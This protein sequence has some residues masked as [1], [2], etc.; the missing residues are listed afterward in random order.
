MHCIA[1][2]HSKGAPHT[3]YFVLR[4]QIGTLS[5]RGKVSKR[6]CSSAIETNVVCMDLRKPCACFARLARL[7]ALLSIHVT[8]HRDTAVAVFEL[9]EIAAAWCVSGRAYHVAHRHRRPAPLSKHLRASGI[10]TPSPSLSGRWT[11]V[12][13]SDHGRPLAWPA[14][15]S[16]GAW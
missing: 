14:I 5:V 15:Y 12:S 2:S 16:M 4:A 1:Q 8:V 13:L 11:I 9:N 6:P 3:A 7:P 10:C